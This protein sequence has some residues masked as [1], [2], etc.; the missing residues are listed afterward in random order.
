MA[1]VYATCWDNMVKIQ[2]DNINPYLLS[3]QEPMNFVKS[4][5]ELLA[6]K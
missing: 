2:T 6:N 3:P 1:Y 4:V 5:E